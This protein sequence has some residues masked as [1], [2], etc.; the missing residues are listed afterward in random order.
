MAFP[1]FPI[2]NPTVAP[3]TVRGGPNG[4]IGADKLRQVP[5]PAGTSP[6]LEHRVAE[7]WLA[8]VATA[9][10]AGFVMSHTGCYRPYGRQV[11]LFLERHVEDP[12]GPK[13]WDGRRWRL[14]A[15]AANAAIPGTSPHGLGCAIDVSLGGFG[16]DA[17]S[18]TEAWA[19]WA[20]D[21]VPAYGFLWSLQSEPWHIQWVYGD[22]VPPALR[23]TPPAP[24]PDPVEDD[25]RYLFLDAPGRPGAIVALDGAG[26]TMLRCPTAGDAERL[27][28]AYGATLVP[29]L[30]TAMYDELVRV[31]G[32]S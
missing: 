11:D 15:G 7:A 29:G 26:V 1:R 6:W 20:L 25:V 3:S 14:K 17:K 21:V 32:A 28:A 18:V 9:A 22:D 30:T 19:L 5:G 16:K 13:W 4:K 27:I 24:V 8:L 10:R 31:E 23:F 12:N 2:R